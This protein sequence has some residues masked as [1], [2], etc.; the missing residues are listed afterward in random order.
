MM[1][2]PKHFSQVF[3][4][5]QNLIKKLKLNCD[6]GDKIIDLKEYGFNLSVELKKNND[7][8][9]V[10][11]YDYRELIQTVISNNDFTLKEDLFEQKPVK[12][13]DNYWIE[14]TN[15]KK[16]YSDDSEFPIDADSGFLNQKP[17]FQGTLQQEDW[18]SQ[19][20]DSILNNIAKSDDRPETPEKIL[21][22]RTKLQKP[23]ELSSRPFVC[24][25][26]DCNSAF[27]RYEHLK[28]HNRIHTG[29]RP[30]KCPFPGCYK[31][32]ARSDN[33]N[34]HLKIHNTKSNKYSNDTISFYRNSY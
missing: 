25:F 22:K 30:F 11:P 34:Q 29:E 9:Y 18:N 13:D 15:L 10:Q 6:E 17:F 3:E 19:M 14:L 32:F 23:T 5:I 7:K 20:I 12:V 2:N 31:K 21:V 1:K 28:R 8:I 24:T 26:K 16:N 4:I 27:K 33:L